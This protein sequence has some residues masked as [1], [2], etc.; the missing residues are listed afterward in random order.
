MKLKLCP[1]LF[2]Q[3]T[4]SGLYVETCNPTADYQFGQHAARRTRTRRRGRA[5]KFTDQSLRSI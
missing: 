3:P 2:D 5:P 1:T 4:Q